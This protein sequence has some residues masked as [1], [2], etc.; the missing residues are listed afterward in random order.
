MKGIMWF[1]EESGVLYQHWQPHMEG[2][3]LGIEQLV[4]LVV[5]WRIAMDIVGPLMSRRSG[6][7]YV[8]VTM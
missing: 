7:K 8:L 3:G 2:E 1:Y 6:N 4:L 5:D